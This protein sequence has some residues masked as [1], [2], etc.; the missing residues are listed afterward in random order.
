MK[1]ASRRP[2]L[3]FRAGWVGLVLVGMAW[4]GLAIWHCVKPIPEGLNLAGPLRGAEHVAFLADETWVDQHGVRQ[5]DHR[6]FE[7]KL[8]LINQA[9]SLVVADFFLFNE[10][11]GNPDGVDLR[12]LSSEMTEALIRRREEHPELRIVFI[13]DPINTLYEGVDAAQFDA[14]RSAG[15]ELVIT[16]LEPLRDSNPAW[17]GLWRLCCRWLGNSPGGVL[18]NPVGNEPVS[19]RTWLRMAN[20]K[21]NHRKTL[22]VDHGETWTGL[23]TSANP[24]DASSAHGN[25]AIEFS[26][27][28]ALDLL[29]SERAILEFSAPDL[30]L[31]PISS[32]ENKP[33]NTSES[34]VRVLTEAAIRD[35]VIER[36]AE[37]GQGSRVDLAMFYLSHR[38]IVEA[39][40]QA[41]E[42]GAE[43][44]VL[45]DP[46]EHAF[47]RNKNGV[48]N[49]PV[50]AELVRA[51]IAVRW[52]HTNGE[53]C[54]SKQ[55]L[56]RHADERIVLIGGSANFTRRNLDNFNPETGVEWT[57]NTQDTQA[58]AA[59]EWFERRWTN[60]EGR[61]Y[62]LDYARYADERRW[63]YWQYRL[64][65]ATGLSTF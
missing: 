26:G 12:P 43:V 11:A 22:I 17:S 19:L 9:E 52:C 54:H 59:M 53:Q 27:P 42:R 38:A 24:H 28:A 36:L 21:A 14:L 2:N 33:E 62:S 58:K 50:A 48:P 15:V 39:I 56:I 30:E 46:N 3:L 41:H 16:S 55:L 57:A 37:A 35:A 29:A 18:P 32:I 31:P 65:E 25:M 61:S 47:G 10:F 45:L 34:R 63:R 4:T 49:R 23:V 20:F 7:R 5:L 44:R 13:T 51:G 64:M 60:A 40:I 6:I 1:Q 8:E